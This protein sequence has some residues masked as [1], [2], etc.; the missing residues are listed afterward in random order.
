M[1]SVSS[2]TTSS[3]AQYASSVSSLDTNGDG[4]VSAEEQAAGSARTQD[5]TVTTDSAA[6]SS[7]SQLSADLMALALAKGD[8]SS[9]DASSMESTIQAREAAHF[10]SM[11]TDGDGKVSEKEFV[12]S[13]PKE[14][15]EEDATKR[16]ESLDTAKTGSLTQ[17]QLESQ[18]PDGGPMGGMDMNS[19]NKILS[20]DSDSDSSSDTMSM[21]DVFSKMSSVIAAYRSAGGT[22]DDTST[23]AATTATSTATK[24]SVTV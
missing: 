20:Q 11:D 22:A 10:N 17:D 16:F 7:T 3:L 21:D 4:V 24:D 2:T 12:D 8:T 9:T 23:S 13:R 18:K 6:T 14:V 1:T 15:S 5:P 19:L